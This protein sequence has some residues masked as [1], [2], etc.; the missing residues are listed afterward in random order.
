MWPSDLNSGACHRVDCCPIQTQWPG[1]L[2]TK[3]E[4]D[5]DSLG[6]DVN[7]DVAIRAR[8]SGS[9]NPCLSLMALDVDLQKTSISC[10]VILTVKGAKTAAP[11]E[12]QHIELN[13]QNNMLFP[14]KA[15]C[16]RMA[17]CAGRTTSLF[18]FN[19]NAGQYHITRSSFVHG[20]QEVLCRGGYEGSLGHSF[21]V[22]GAFL[23][24]ALGVPVV[25]IC[26]LGHWQSL[27]Y[28]L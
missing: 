5:N 7:S 24:R 17:N 8:F 11:G 10:K 19:S 21:P 25:Q 26:L 3:F 2:A 28:Q 1:F 16:W 9:V 6:S 18:G 4:L 15:I 22:G 12:L 14:V 23:R 20:V 27:C 13:C